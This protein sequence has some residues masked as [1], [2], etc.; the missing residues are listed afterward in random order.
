[1][2]KISKLELEVQQFGLKIQIDASASSD[3]IRG[4]DVVLTEIEI[5]DAPPH[6]Q[7]TLQDV[8]E[9]VAQRLDACGIQLSFEIARNLDTGGLHLKTISMAKRFGAQ[10]PGEQPQLSLT[11]WGQVWNWTVTRLA[12]KKGDA[13]KLSG[14]GNS[15]DDLLKLTVTELET[16]TFT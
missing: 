12:K 9:Y 8:F 6:D 15:I 11:E 16:V 1:M 14:T 10:V 4:C 2:T 3:R 5:D 13:K 7:V